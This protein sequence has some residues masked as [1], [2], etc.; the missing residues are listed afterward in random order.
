MYAE[1]LSPTKM[2]MY[3]TCPERYWHTVEAGT[4]EKHSFSAH[5]GSCFH[6][7]MEV[8]VKARYKTDF[9]NCVDWVIAN[10]EP[11]SKSVRDEAIRIAERWI[12]HDDTHLPR[13]EKI[14]AVEESFGPPDSTIR[15]KPINAAIKFDSGLKVRGIIDIVWEDGDTIVVGDYKTQR[16]MIDSEDL[17]AKTQAQLYALAIHK[18]TGR[19]IRVE[20]YMIRYPEGGPVVWAPKEEDYPDI[21]SYLWAIQNRIRNDS[22]HVAQPSLE[23]RWCP[24]NYTCK[25]FDM[26][27]TAAPGNEPLPATLEL[28]AIVAK[29]DEWNAKRITAAKM[30]DD[31]KHAALQVM[32]QEHIDRCGK[33]KVTRRAKRNYDQQGQIILAENDGKI[34]PHMAVTMSQHQFTTYGKPY[35]QRV[36]R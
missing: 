10:V 21:E 36:R 11:F 3:L 31:F 35:L 16:Y 25:P 24:F 17:A 7:A 15:G 8:Y 22:T 19:M 30:E 2:D 27:H 18:L 13:F 4:T 1:I 26:W 20:F 33:F 12:Y 28:E 14:S 9:S 6:E 29:Y 34:P 5:V 23:C 32:S